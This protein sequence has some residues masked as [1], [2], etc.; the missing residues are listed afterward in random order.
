MET[1][2][3]SSW[4]LDNAW[5]TAPRQPPATCAFMQSPCMI[6]GWPTFTA[7]ANENVH[8][9]TDVAALILSAACMQLVLAG[10][11]EAC[12]PLVGPVQTHALAEGRHVK[13]AVRACCGQGPCP[14]EES[15][16]STPATTVHHGVR[17]S[18]DVRSAGLRSP[19]GKIYVRVGFR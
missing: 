6:P 7:K 8:P 11:E 9:V 2:S 3:Y 1:S 18:G 14:L 16:S 12:L 15:V 5:M 19:E 4:M 13:D 10:T 17:R